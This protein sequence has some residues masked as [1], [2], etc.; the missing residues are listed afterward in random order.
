MIYLNVLIISLFSLSYGIFFHRIEKS[1][2]SGP[3]FALIVGAVFGSMLLNLAEITLDNEE[4]K[5]LA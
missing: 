1:I 2:I 4:Y 5:L 3:I